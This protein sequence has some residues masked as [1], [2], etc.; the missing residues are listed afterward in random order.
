[1]QAASELGITILSRGCTT[2][3]H[4][5]P[6]TLLHHASALPAPMQ[7]PSCC[8]MCWWLLPI[9]QHHE[10]HAYFLHSV[11]PCS[12]QLDSP[13]LNNDALSAWAN[14][15][16]YNAQK[17]CY[18]LVTLIHCYLL[19]AVGSYITSQLYSWSTQKCIFVYLPIHSPLLKISVLAEQLARWIN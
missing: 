10:P 18:L 9:L 17:H 3:G 12:H 14:K 1:M 2:P 5:P 13:L 4:P 7:V 6:S 8:T 19:W 11:L 15:N 16:T